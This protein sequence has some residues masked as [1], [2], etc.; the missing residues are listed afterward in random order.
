MLQVIMP[1][2]LRPISRR[3]FLAQTVAGAGLALGSELFGASKHSDPDFWALLADTHL[4]ADRSHVE[5]GVNMSDNFAKVAAELLASAQRPAGVF[6]TGDCAF[7]SGEQG[8]YSILTESLEPI[9]KARMPVHLALG[10]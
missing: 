2:H 5:R 4:A 6:I 3:Q 8:D 1:I 10:N 9:R 7:N